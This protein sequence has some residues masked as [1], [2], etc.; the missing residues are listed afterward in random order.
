MKISMSL[1]LC[2]FILKSY[3]N[4]CLA[5]FRLSTL[6]KYEKY[7]PRI[8]VAF[9]Q[10]EITIFP[11]HQHVHLSIPRFIFRIAKSVIFLM[12]TNGGELAEI[13]EGFTVHLS[14]SCCCCGG[15]FNS[16]MSK[17]NNQ[18]FFI[19][20]CTFHTV[21]GRF[22]ANTWSQRLYLIRQRRDGEKAPWF[23]YS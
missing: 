5:Q 6:R 15:G 17:L 10:G 18:V 16:S 2:T 14:R 4:Y 19:H 21:F 8:T 20:L 7:K 23:S 11:H 13:S 22:K 3:R 1:N 12:N 9:Y